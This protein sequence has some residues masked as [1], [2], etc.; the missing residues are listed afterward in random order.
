[1]PF[2]FDHYLECAH[3]QAA[4]LNV[5]LTTPEIILQFQILEHHHT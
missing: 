4:A 1:M 3:T 2:K 5:S